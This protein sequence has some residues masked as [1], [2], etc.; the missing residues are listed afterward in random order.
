MSEKTNK[1]N[2]LERY[3]YEKLT[4]ER[5][6]SSDNRHH[7]LNEKE[8]QDLKKIKYQTFV[9]AGVT[10]ALAVVVLYFPFYLFPDLFPDTN[11]WVPLMDKY[12]AI[13]IVFFAYS[14]ILVVIEIALLMYFNISAV[15]GISHACGYPDPRDPHFETDVNALIAVGLE[16][17]QKSQEA[18]GIDP[19]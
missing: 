14:M 19:V 11:V 9:K 18:L 15:K 12:Y 5:A 1:K 4:E 7:I 13:P 16:R 10:G 2:R 6:Y 3:V 8:Q 17:K